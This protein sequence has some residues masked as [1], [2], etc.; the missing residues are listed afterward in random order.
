M[1]SIKFYYNSS[2]LNFA[3]LLLFFMMLILS[4]LILKWLSSKLLFVMNF[5]KFLKSKIKNE[6]IIW[7]ILHVFLQF[8]LISIVNDAINFKQQTAATIISI[9][10]VLWFLIWILFSI[11]ELF[12]LPFIEKLEIWSPSFYCLIVL[13][14]VICNAWLFAFEGNKMHIIWISISLALQLISIIVHIWSS[15]EYTLKEIYERYSIV[16]KNS[17]I[18]VILILIFIDE[19][20]S[21][22]N[23]NWRTIVILTTVFFVGSLFLDILTNQVMIQELQ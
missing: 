7:L 10:I 3:N 22:S 18:T 16:I 2:V 11:P 4:M 8:I 1:E 14:K 12:S 6:R 19:V 13:A 20:F 23:L 15:R 5:Y 21:N 17:M 9:W